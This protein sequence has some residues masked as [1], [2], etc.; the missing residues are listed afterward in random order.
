[1]TDLQLTFDAVLA[2]VSRAV[3]CSSGVALCDVISIKSPVKWGV[4]I[5]P[6]S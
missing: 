6:I 2:P 4:C 5:C 3:H 1:M